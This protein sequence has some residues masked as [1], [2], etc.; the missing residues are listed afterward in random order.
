MP[1]T[2]SSIFKLKSRKKGT[3]NLE[4]V[5]VRTSSLNKTTALN[6]MLTELD[7]K[8]SIELRKEQMKI[9]SGGKTHKRRRHKRRRSTHKRR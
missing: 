5:P 1:K 9:K 3:Y 7:K 4:P 8:D 6:K 2:K